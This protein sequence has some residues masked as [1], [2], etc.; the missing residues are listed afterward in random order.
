MV[1]IYVLSLDHE[2]YYIG[3]TEN[4]NYRIKEHYQH[5]G[6]QWTKKYKP[7]S[8][9]ELIPNCDE[10]DEDK[11]TLKYM[12]KYGINNVRGGSFCQI[13]LSDANIVTLEQIMKSV[14]D[15]CYICGK[16]GHFANKCENI[17][18]K[19]D[20]IPTVDVNGEC[21][22]ITSFLSPHR[23]KKCAIKNI[24]SYFDDEYGNMDKL[25]I[26]EDADV[27]D[28]DVENTVVDAVVEDAVV[29]DT[30]VE[31]VK[32][33]CSRCGRNSHN[34]NKCYATKH[35]TGYILTKI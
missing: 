12:E 35:L 14:K 7:K 24:M 5:N 34:A 9:V 10:Y 20:K 15:K 26:V 25:I 16:N 18:I 19:Q 3:K 31:K 22:C 21:D 1:F 6:S 4:P 30:V 2:K 29:K 8:V 28:A 17:T 27:K 23:I 32:T 13:I 33:L 11:Y